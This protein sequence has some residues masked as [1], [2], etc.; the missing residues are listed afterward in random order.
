MLEGSHPLRNLCAQNALLHSG[1]TPFE[2]EQLQAK[3]F[4]SYQWDEQDN[5]RIH[6]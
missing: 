6:E 4:I 1:P 2:E 5:V 3:V